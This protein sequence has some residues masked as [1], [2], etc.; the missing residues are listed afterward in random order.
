MQSFDEETNVK[1]AAEILDAPAEDIAA[2]IKSPKSSIDWQSGA[3]LS[4]TMRDKAKR[5]RQM[6]FL[7]NF[8]ETGSLSEACQFAGIN[9]NTELKWRK[10]DVWF[11]KQFSLAY[12]DFKDKIEKEILNRAITGEQVP[13]VGK[14]QTPLGPE[15][16]IIGH[17]T[18]KSDILLMFMAKK[19]MQE[20]K[21]KYEAPKV[22]VKVEMTSPMDRISRQLEAMKKREKHK[23]LVTN[24]VI[25][26]VPEPEVDHE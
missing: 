18:V 12:E 6:S 22:E 15:D 14:V 10:E 13:I 9:R 7:K 2:L 26:V 16:V 1:N 21:D 23:E 19:H 5:H 4:V 25:E 3:K 20:Y 24:T 8:K 11:Q 17:K